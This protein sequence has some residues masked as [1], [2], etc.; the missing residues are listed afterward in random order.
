MF[1]GGE[2]NLVKIW[3]DFF[4]WKIF[5]FW[6]VLEILSVVF[7]FLLSSTTVLYEDS[8]FEHESF[9]KISGKK[10]ERGP[11]LRFSVKILNFAKN[12]DFAEIPWRANRAREIDFLRVSDHKIHCGP[13][14]ARNV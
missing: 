1:Y 13:C 8:D 11:G 3:P 14:A 7:N 9:Q 12:H 5:D 2:A 10:F 6:C 4:Q